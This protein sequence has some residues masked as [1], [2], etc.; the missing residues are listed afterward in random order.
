MAQPGQKSFRGWGQEVGDRGRRDKKC[1]RAS[2]QT[3][4]HGEGGLTPKQMEKL[5]IL[6][7]GGWDEVEGWWMG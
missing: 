3:L 1:H 7:G 4:F 6:K 5:P 2:L